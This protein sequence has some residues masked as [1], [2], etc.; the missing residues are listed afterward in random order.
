VAD[1]VGP[2]AFAFEILTQ[3]DIAV[4]RDDELLTLTTDYTVSIDSDGT[5]TITLTAAPTGADQIALVGARAIERVSDFTTGG[6]FFAVTVNEELDSLTIFAQQN[7]EAV[8]RAL[9]APQT[10]PLSIDMTLPRASVR[11]GKYLIF[12]SS[13]NPDAGDTVTDVST[14]AGI[15][16]Q[17]VTVSGISNQVVTVANND[18]NVTTVAGISGNVT[19]VAGISANVTTVA[20]N[21]SNINTVSTNIAN[22]NTT[23]TNITNVN[24]TGS[25]ITNVNSVAANLGTDLPVTVVSANLLGTNTIGTVAGSITNVN[26]VGGSIANV[27]EV[28]ANIGTDLPVSV[29]SDNLLGTDTIGTVAGSIANVNTVGG[30]IVNVNAVAGNATNI[31]AVAS[32]ATNINKVAAIDAN[33]TKV[34]NIDTNVTKV[35]DIDT[36]VTTVAGISTNVTTVAGISGNVTTVAGISANV[37]SVAGNATNI[38]TVAGNTTNINTVATNN[39]NVTTV[40][41]NIADVNTVAAALATPLSAANAVSYDNT[42]SG[43]TATNVQTAIDEVED[44]VD[45]LEDRVDDAEDEI[46]RIDTLADARLRE[47][48]RKEKAT[49]IAPSLLLDFEGDKQLDP[50]VTFARASTARVYDGKT[51][52][53]AEENFTFPSNTLSGG[54]FVNRRVTLATNSTTAPDGTATASLVAEDTNTNSHG[55]DS[56]VNVVSGL[57]YTKS[58]FVKKGT[59]AT[60]PD[61]VQIPVASSLLTAGGYANFDISVGGGTSGTVTA[62]SGNVTASIVSAGNGWYRCAVTFTATASTTAGFV[63]DGLLYLTNNN[64]T[65]TQFTSYAGQTSSDVFLWG[66]QYEQRASATAYTP[67]TTQ[68]ITNYI[69]VLQSAANNVARFDHNPVTGESL[70]LL[71]EEQR[72]N[73]LLRSEEFDNASWQK[74]RASVTSNIIIAPDGTLSGD[75]AIETTDTGTHEVYQGITATAAPYTGTVYFKAGERTKVFLYLA[76]GG[77]VFSGIFDLIAG[78]FG[79]VTA[80]T[81][82]TITPVGNGWY[83]CSITATLT[84][85]T[86]FLGFIPVTGTTTISYTGDGYS[87]IYVWGASLEQGSFSTSYIKTEAS[88]VTRSADSASMTGANFSGWYSQGEGTVY[89][90]GRYSG[91]TT[92]LAMFTLSDN[93]FNNR[94]TGVFTTSGGIGVGFEVIANGAGQTTILP[95]SITPVANTQYKIAASFKT[96]NIAASR[97]GGVAGTDTSAIIPVVDRIYIGANANGGGGRASA[98][99]SKLAFYPKV[100]TAANLQ[101]L[102][103]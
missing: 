55:V 80:S 12:D 20:N 24:A 52:A 74:L 49:P 6:D 50:R 82:A 89:W 37:T 11:A 88:Q 33:V 76:S 71:V 65:A 1:G 40:A 28:A 69:P 75:K 102:T 38:N 47:A 51:V 85:T 61:I 27:N 39:A 91:I 26:A 59:G 103:S 70:G 53:K 63:N 43:L 9:S 42:S 17:V 15:A 67:T 94:M 95:S 7:A 77:V 68:P 19:T 45:D 66:A 100:L 36:N 84:A 2:Y 97:N 87:G 22:V 4:F 25:N 3:T 18:A 96:D 62:N 14:V 32:N 16:S 56:G 21:T 31:N 34:A 41:T 29:V 54:S 90:D 58:V 93:T 44:R 72:T 101:A 83:R 13:G 48:F 86:W 79:S 73:L 46:V 98:T 92:G 99:I 78:T 35:A 10:D 60:A 57:S 23:A 30:S 81:T 5:G 64:P 8:A